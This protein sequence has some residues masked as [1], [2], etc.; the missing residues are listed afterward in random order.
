MAFHVLMCLCIL[1]RTSR[2]CMNTVLYRTCWNQLQLSHGKKRHAILG[3]VL[4]K[5]WNNSDYNSK[6]QHSA[7]PYSMALCCP[8]YA[9]CV[10]D[11][12][13]V[14]VSVCDIHLVS[15]SIIILHVPICACMSMSVLF[16]FCTVN[17]SG[18]SSKCCLHPPFFIVIC[19]SYHLRAQQHQCSTAC[20]ANAAFSDN[21]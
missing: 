1:Y 3:C 13:E 21:H 7:L 8:H 15:Q 18:L 19:C 9:S 4:H 2:L 6:L 14:T 16:L 20:S 11:H 10:Q 17:S 5:I 12:G